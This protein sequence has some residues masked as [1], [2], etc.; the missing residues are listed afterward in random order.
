MSKKRQNAI[1]DPRGDPAADLTT[2]IYDYPAFYFVPEHFHA[3]AQLVFSSRGVMTMTVGSELWVVP[4]NKAVWIP[5]KLEHS[6]QMSRSVSMRT[7]Y[8]AP[9]LA[10]R[11]S[12]HCHV[13]SVSPLLRELILHCCEVG[14]LK[15][16]DPAQVPLIQVVLS[17]IARAKS[18]PLSISHPKDARAIKIAKS[19]LQNPGEQKTLGELCREAGSSKRT[20]ERA[21]LGETGMSFGKWR[22]QVRLIHG[23]KLVAEGEKITQA[24]IEAGYSSPSAFISMFRKTLGTT[25]SRYF[26]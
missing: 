12:G 13:V 11:L 17:Q 9:K 7:L 6:I 22:Q 16:K 24:A 23:I 26:V 2:L 20:I 8:F 10:R 15:V 4:P 1:L 14:K 25:P 3:E 21:F 5:P 18:M 19:V